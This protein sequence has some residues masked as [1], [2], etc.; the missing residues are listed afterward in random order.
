[1]P[2]TTTTALLLGATAV[3]AAGAV[4]AGSAEKSQSDFSA[5]DQIQQAAIERAIAKEEEIDFRRGASRVAA[6][7]QATG[8]GSGVQLNTGSNLLVKQDHAA[9][10]ELQAQRIRQGGKS[11][12]QRLIEQAQLTKSA[13][14]AA[15]TRGFFRAGASLLTGASKTF[16]V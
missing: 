4:A 9:E 3:S 13:G 10:V 11:Q 7:S 8:G 15:Q 16:S 12:S 2:F 14:K 1:M 6:T 5:A